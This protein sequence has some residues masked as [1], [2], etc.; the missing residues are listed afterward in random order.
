MH[1]T[2][3]STEEFV[4]SRLHSDSLSLWRKFQP[5]PFNSAE[6]RPR[7]AGSFVVSKKSIQIIIN[8]GQ[9]I[10]CASQFHNS[11]HLLVY[12]TLIAPLQA[13]IFW[14]RG[15]RPFATALLPSTVIPFSFLLIFC[16]ILF[17]CITSSFGSI[18]LY[19]GVA[20]SCSRFAPF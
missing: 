4:S 1:I 15:R 2:P 7:G 16:L 8:F 10:H 14:E 11:I 20:S 6:G 3:S 12:S 13:V 17:F 5:L 9:E 19:F 18:L